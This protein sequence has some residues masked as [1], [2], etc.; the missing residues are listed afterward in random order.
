MPSASPPIPGVTELN[1]SQ[2]Q[3]ANAL[4]GLNELLEKLSKNSEPKEVQL[5]ESEYEQRQK[6]LKQE[7]EYLAS[8]DEVSEAQ[9]QRA[10]QVKEEIKTS[11]EKSF[12]DQKIADASNSAIKANQ[13]AL[14]ATTK[15]L[16]EENKK[17]IEEAQKA[18]IRAIAYETDKEKRNKLIKEESE[19]RKKLTDNLVENNKFESKALAKNRQ[20]QMLEGTKS[21]FLDQLG[22]TGL[23]TLFGGSIGQGS[24][25][26]LES[27]KAQEA[28]YKAGFKEKNEA[29]TSKMKADEFSKPTMNSMEG[30]SS[31]KP[32]KFSNP[33]MNSMEGLSSEKPD[34]GGSSDSAL[35]KKVKNVLKP[36]ASDLM[37]LPARIAMGFL[38][39]GEKLGG[40]KS[41]GTASD[42]GI[43]G[44]FGGLFKKLGPFFKKL[45]GPLAKI[46]SKFGA[47]VLKIFSKAGSFIS[48][49][50]SKMF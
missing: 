45:F 17:R 27:L 34:K 20:Q 19:F 36:T 8:L 49:I 28:D 46:F 21:H 40:A 14:D 12:N 13:E 35:D 23:S 1:D 50:F 15:R 42:A 3:L 6:A 30:L 2:K 4:V 18:R 11:T 26:K 10:L 22:I 5:K 37:K 41:G 48:K 7:E 44:M 25:I 32:D 31:E 24:K 16:D 29:E 39:L 33:T 47:S 38:Y 9:Y 43:F